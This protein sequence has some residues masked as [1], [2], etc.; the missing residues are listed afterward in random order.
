M[1]NHTEV[2]SLQECVDRV[3]MVVTDL[4]G[5]IGR[6]V[7]DEITIADLGND[8][9]G[10]SVKLLKVEETVSE[11]LEQAES[12][13][14]GGDPCNSEESQAPDIETLMEWEEEGGCEATDG[15]WV[16]PDGAC[17]HGCQSWLLVLGL[18]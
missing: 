10:L 17:E 2:Q 1:T 12:T 13:V 16:E 9:A 14:P 4:N 5:F 7:N 15:C 11:L 3:A 6:I 8:L 18:I